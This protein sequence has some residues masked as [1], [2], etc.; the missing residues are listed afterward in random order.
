MTDLA[1]HYKEVSPQETVQNVKDFFT[2]HG[3]SITEHDLNPSE[4]NTWYCRV[5]LF[6]GELYIGSSNGKGMTKEYALASGYAE[7]YERFANQMF[8]F[9]NYYWNHTLIKENFNK[10]GYYFHPNEKLMTMDEIINNCEKSKD[11][12]DRYTGQNKELQTALLDILI[13]GQ[14]VAVP[15]PSIDSTKTDLFIDPRMLKFYT[16]SNGMV[17]GNT[18]LE[19]LNQG[20]SE[21]FERIA[22]NYMLSH[23]YEPFYYIDL[24]KITNP[25]L[26]K[27]ID[28]IKSLG[29]DF[30]IFDLSY[31]CKV[32][33]LMSLLVDSKTGSINYN[34]GCFPVFDIALERV[35]TELYQ[36]VRSY[37]TT[38][39][40][41]N[42]QVPSRIFSYEEYLQL[43]GNG[44]TGCSVPFEILLNA[45]PV[46]DYN[47][48]IFI[49]ENKSN[50]EIFNYY[51]NLSN[52][53]NY[54]IYYMDN[55]LCDKIYA[56]HVFIANDVS[57]NNA[58][59]VDCTNPY[60]YIRLCHKLYA[61]LQAIIN[62]KADYLALISF[63][64]EL[65]FAPESDFAPMTILWGNFNISGSIAE[66]FYEYNELLN[67]FCLTSNSN[68]ILPPSTT[69]YKTI[70]YT[71]MHQVGT[72]YKFLLT[73]AYKKD[74]ILQIFN[75]IYHF[76]ISED[77]FTYF[78]N[79]IYLCKKTYFEPLYKV[80]QSE[81]YKKII[82]TF[83]K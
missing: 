78:Q 30:Y 80:L 71:I 62:Y 14:G 13:E 79:R 64:T 3:Y 77:D 17:A 76:N 24:D 15:C 39:A 25:E 83:I 9:G 46:S 81:E 23:L 59:K 56:L 10:Y 75:K 4:I 74:E 7:L 35:C 40:A 63:L 51:I 49:S 1:H 68:N 34:Y 20:I 48:D 50:E 58:H 60:I 54:K 70:F 28:M 41:L 33:T 43:C 18:K 72:L 19:A 12:F 65:K 6:Q 44:N 21:L 26:K 32:P 31:Q 37:K 27:R 52:T 57:D 55:S 42:Y 73:H 53:L 29:Y 66:G 2:S 5:D 82:Q 61:L 47:K 22:Q 16:R 36:G 8:F 45:V 38:D 11:W 67:N 69:F